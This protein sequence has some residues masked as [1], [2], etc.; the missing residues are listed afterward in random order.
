MIAQHSFVKKNNLFIV[1]GKVYR[2]FV[3][4][5]NTKCVYTLIAP[6]P[7]SNQNVKAS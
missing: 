3:C 5:Q 4:V 7:K 2:S 6:S 1:D